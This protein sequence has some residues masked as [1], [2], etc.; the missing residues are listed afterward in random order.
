MSTPKPASWSDPAEARVT[1]DPA[2]Q[3]ASFLRQPE[4]KPEPPRIFPDPLDAVALA[5]RVPAE[6]SKW[7]RSTRIAYY[8]ECRKAMA[9]LITHEQREL[10]YKR[11]LEMDCPGCGQNK[12]PAGH[13][14]WR[15]SLP[16]VPSEWYDRKERYPGKKM[17]PEQ[18]AAAIERLARGRAK[19]AAKAAPKRR[20]KA[21]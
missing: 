13:A 9:T 8:V 2:D 15:C 6:R 16:V 14:C 3:R 10:A 18:R 1:I 5:A 19:V 17:D 21:A 20:R 4:P 12:Q 7:D 11:R